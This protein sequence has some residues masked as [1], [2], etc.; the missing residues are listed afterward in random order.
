MN[1]RYLLLPPILMLMV[2]PIVSIGCADE[3]SRCAATGRLPSEQAE[4]FRHVK[5]I[6]LEVREHYEEAEK[7][8]IPFV[9]E[10]PRLL[11]EGA[12]FT[13]VGADAKQF[14]ATLTVDLKGTASE[15]TE[16]PNGRRTVTANLAG[17]ITLMAGAASYQRRLSTNSPG[18]V[19][20]DGKV[21]LTSSYRWSLQETNFL[22]A[23]LKMLSGALGIS[24]PRPLA[25]ALACEDFNFQSKIVERLARCGANA[26][27]PLLALLK[28]DNWGQRAEPLRRWDS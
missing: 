24:P 23:S 26:V 18:R 11:L 6:R 12:G 19:V 27:G 7:Q 22:D 9:R 4:A 13:L 16:P 2:L 28:K 17:T 25:A 21:N 20:A 3:A 1:F 15:T 8:S 14:D 5:T 10:L